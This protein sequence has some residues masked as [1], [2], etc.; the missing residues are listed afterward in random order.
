MDIEDNVYLDHTEAHFIEDP[1]ECLQVF[2]SPPGTT[3]TAY[4]VSGTSR[5]NYD[6][7]SFWNGNSTYD[8]DVLSVRR[9]NELYGNVISTSINSI[10]IKVTRRYV[11]DTVAFSLLITVQ[12]GLDY[13]LYLG[14]SNIRGNA[15]NG[16][17]VPLM[18]R[19]LAITDSVV[20][21]NGDNGIR[22]V[23][24]Y[25]KIDLTNTVVNNNEQS[26]LSFASDFGETSVLQSDFCRN[27]L[28]GV[29]IQFRSLRYHSYKLTIVNSSASYNGQTGI[30]GA[31]I[32]SSCYTWSFCLID[33]AI[34]GN[35]QKGLT[36]D[37]YYS[38]Y[39]VGYVN[40][41]RNSFV[42]NNNGGADLYYIASLAIEYNRF[43]N[44]TGEYSC[45]LVLPRTSSAISFAKIQNNTFTDNSGESVVKV[46]DNIYY[47]YGSA[48]MIDIADNVFDNNT[49]FSVISFD[50]EQSTSYSATDAV[51]IV[52]NM[53]IN[54]VA[55]P[56]RSHL[57]HTLPVA[58]IESDRPVLSIVQN[59]FE[60][61]LF[62]FELVI[63]GDHHGEIINAKF[64]Y[65]ST[66]DE[67]EIHERIYDY[68]DDY[69]FCVVNFFPFL[70]SQDITDVVPL[71]L[72]RSFPMFKRGNTI[73]G[74]L[75]GREVLLNT[76]IDYIVD[77]DITIARGGKLIIEPG[78]HVQLTDYRSVFVRGKLIAIGTP[79]NEI[80]FKPLEPSATRTNATVRLVDGNAPTEGRLEL[81]IGDVWH[82]MCYR[83]WSLNNAKVVCRQLGFVHATTS[84]YSAPAGGTGPIFNQPF[85]CVGS[86]FSLQQCKPRDDYSGSC[87]YHSQD[88]AIRCD[89]P[90]WGGLYFPVDSSVSV[91]KHV[92]IHDAGYKLSWPNT[93]NFIRGEAVLIHLHHHILEDV[94][95]QSPWKKSQ[96]RRCDQ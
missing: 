82:T 75:H 33:T 18:N 1:L 14:S 77:R 48:F 58:T 70:N 69:Q 91:L 29:D 60:N 89:A 92:D 21:F 8:A 64:N 42:D 36:I 37:G 20:S 11:Y 93:D 24:N 55:R 78:V 28:H 10:T 17:T 3:L 25:G 56:Y 45:Q 81:L 90:R 50:W 27:G 26:G 31:Y 16:I 39:N 59:I 85:D 4:I 49:C 43:V 41:T 68:N 66:N 22:F 96:L 12:R 88:V 83:Y 53:F 44:N 94:H 61:P 54:N 65:W 51:S 32:P 46:S 71:D 47:N 84:R 23:G 15:G 34:V 5:Y 57:L 9:R 67:L 13:D 80:S 52:G 30:K 38:C 79:E 73:G 6:Y 63:V 74:I 19:H 40:I 72:S 2:S 7:L 86:E 62:T 35:G 95:V 87:S 76:G